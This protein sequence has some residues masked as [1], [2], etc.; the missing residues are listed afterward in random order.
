MWIEWP[1][2]NLDA[3]VNKTEVTDNQ[4]AAM[5][6]AKALEAMQLAEASDQE[7]NQ[8]N[9]GA[10]KASLAELEGMIGMPEWTTTVAEGWGF[11]NNEDALGAIRGHFN[12]WW[13]EVTEQPDLYRSEADANN[14]SNNPEE[15]YTGSLQDKNDA[16][17]RADAALERFRKGWAI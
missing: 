8:D 16:Q 7:N 14:Y 15:Y 12:G 13:E 4:I 6:P 2:D 1:K 3:P 17:K 11:R 9:D 10:L 5:N